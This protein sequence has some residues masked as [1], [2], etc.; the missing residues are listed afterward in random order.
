MVE[1]YIEKNIDKHNGL[2]ITFNVTQITYASDTF[3]L[4]LT[5]FAH[6]YPYFLIT[7]LRIGDR[8]SG[9]QRVKKSLIE[10]VTY[11]TASSA[12][13]QKCVGVLFFVAV[14]SSRRA[15]Q[16]GIPLS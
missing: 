13:K 16:W 7:S 9:I 8:I 2:Q 6:N 10:L 4:L 12:N 15:L 1:F 14:S 11:A 5:I 3:S